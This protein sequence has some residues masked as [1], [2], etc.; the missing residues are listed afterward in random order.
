MLVSEVIKLTVHFVYLKSHISNVFKQQEVEDT[1]K[2]L[3]NEFGSERLPDVGFSGTCVLYQ[4]LAQK[5]D[6]WR[7]RYFSTLIHTSAALHSLKHI[8][9]ITI[10][11]CAMET[12]AQE[13]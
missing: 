12:A 3:H 7:H 13:S 1:P 11:A 5:V 6:T 9:A 10:L 8:L 4:Q 2:L